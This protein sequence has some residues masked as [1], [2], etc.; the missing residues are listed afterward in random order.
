M[1]KSVLFVSLALSLSLAFVGC[2]A[3]N[4]SE[5]SAN[6]TAE[7]SVSNSVSDNTVAGTTWVLT[8]AISLD[9]TTGAVT[10]GDKFTGLLNMTIRFEEDNEAIFTTN[11]GENICTYE[12]NGNTLRITGAAGNV[13]VATLTAINDK[14]IMTIQIA[15]TSLT[16]TQQ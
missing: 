10:S 6:P 1:K 15:N 16:F 11:N 9:S 13:W 12:Q 5:T 3:A 2:S 8:D 7:S 14:G 4:E